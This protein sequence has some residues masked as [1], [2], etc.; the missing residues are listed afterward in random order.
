MAVKALLALLSVC[1]AGAAAAQA[2][3]APAP[4]PAWAEP[5]WQ[6]LATRHG[7]ALR[8]RLDPSKQTGDFDGD[9]R[10]D[11]AV[12]VVHVASRK[13]GIAFLFRARPARVVGAGHAFGNGGDD[14]A[15]ID[16][17]ARRVA[18]QGAQRSRRSGAAPRRGRRRRREGKFGQRI[19]LP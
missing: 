10:A 8:N 9:G 18:W 1:L 6:A 15:W 11:V 3:P 5:A 12:L 16:A 2:A 14:F 13:E 4:L 17:L 7:L 19:D